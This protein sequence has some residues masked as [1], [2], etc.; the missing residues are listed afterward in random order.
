V[1]CRTPIHL[2]LIG[3]VSAP[4]ARARDNPALYQCTTIVTGTDMRQR[5]LGFATCLKQVLVKVSGAPRLNDDPA[6]AAM[7]GNADE[8]VSSFSYVDPRAWFLHHDDQGTYDRSY[9]LT[10]RFDPAKINTALAKLGLAPWH[11]PRPLLTPVIL[12]RRDETPYLLSAE[13]PRGTEMR[14]TIVQL[15]SEYG[16]GVHFP[17]AD[18][19]SGWGVTLMGSPAPLGAPDPARLQVT[20]SLNWSVHALGWVGTWQVRLN[21]VEHEWQISGV[22]FDQ[23]FADMVRGA[24][25]LAHGTGTP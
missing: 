5:P 6:V 4:L 13:T 20:G 15:A 23:A 19:L 21:G 22:G 1:N 2:I 17:T 24:V 16:L 12:V 14:Q 10:V 7:A 9:E 11:D 8:L 3:L 18:E 25:M